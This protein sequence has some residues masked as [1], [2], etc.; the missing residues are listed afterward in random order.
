ML[1]EN[2]MSVR[3]VITLVVVIVGSLLLGGCFGKLAGDAYE[4][5][6]YNLWGL[7]EGPYPFTIPP[8]ETWGTFLGIA[9]GLL[10]SLLWCRTMVVRS[11]CPKQSSMIRMGAVLGMLAGVVST[12]VVHFGLIFVM[13]FDPQRPRNKVF[14][15]VT[16]AVGLA[17]GIVSGLLLGALGGRL[18]VTAGQEDAVVPAEPKS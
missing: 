7:P 10:V 11:R 1:H 3:S 8:L 12:L 6:M 9:S 18:C 17:F 16:L 5:Q 14:D 15:I 2:H 4:F 13:A